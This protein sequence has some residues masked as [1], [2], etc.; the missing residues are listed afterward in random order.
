VLRQ[1]V[2]GLPARERT[3]HIP[4]VTYTDPEL[5]QIGPTEAEARGLHGAALRVVR[6]EYHHNDRAITEGQQEGFIK[7]MVV[8]G[9]PV[10]VTIVG[11]AAGELIGLWSL[12]ISQRLK[13]S[14]IAG[15]VAPYPTYGE[16]SKRA[17][18]AFFSPKLFDNPML[19]RVVRLVQAWLP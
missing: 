4:W 3:D 18:G 1:V 7:V 5:A 8:K 19:K 6:A 16:L 17:A 12:A 15:M 11:H 13:M 9:R 10:G 14:A 2:L